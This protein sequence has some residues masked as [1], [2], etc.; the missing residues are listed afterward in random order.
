MSNVSFI[1]THLQNL[2][3]QI[4]GNHGTLTG[5]RN[6]TGSN[7][8]TNTTVSPDQQMAFQSEIIALDQRIAAFE[9]IIS[10][11]AKQGT[12]DFPYDA[13]KLKREFMDEVYALLLRRSNYHSLLQNTFLA[14]NLPGVTIAI[15]DPS[16]LLIS[17]PVYQATGTFPNLTQGPLLWDGRNFSNMTPDQ[18]KNA[19]NDTG[20][21]IYDDYKALIDAV[22][23][24][25]N[26]RKNNPAVT[27]TVVTAIAPREISGVVYDRVTSE[28]GKYFLIEANAV[29]NGVAKT[30]VLN[31]AGQVADFRLDFTGGASVAT[32][33]LEVNADLTPIAHA[34]VQ[35]RTQQRHLSLPWFLYFWNE[36]RV[37]ILRS[38]L[39]MKE[40]VTS[41][42]RDDL[43]KANAVLGDLEAQA[44]KT[45]SQSSDGKT[46]NPDL[47]AETT[48]MDFWEAMSAKPGQTIFDADGLDDT[49]NFAQW[50]TN[51]SQ[52][53]AYID[54]K[55]TQSQDA[56]LE[57]Q[58]MLNRYNNAFEVMSKMQ[59]KLDNLLKSQLRNIG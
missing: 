28:N 43:A 32:K 44:G 16:G 6:G 53:R 21:R 22:F 59:E 9:Q 24:E 26:T 8:G 52:L 41:E 40:A 50:Q 57:Y 5:F 56:M 20:R 25:G 37:R 33:Y 11:G 45:R 18:Q 17:R 29:I 42:I 30:N 48:R 10:D 35:N 39:A 1:S 51:R 36:A 15:A 27:P 14:P 3:N 19:L 58:T 13:E 38:Q 49:H 2:Y 47:S 31:T 4:G 7:A 23:A 34:V 46:V 55:S 12:D 54:L